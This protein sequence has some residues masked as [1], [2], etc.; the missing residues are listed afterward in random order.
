MP[1]TVNNKRE[2]NALIA[3]GIDGSEVSVNVEETNLAI[4]SIEIVVPNKS[5]VKS[6]K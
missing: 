5:K 2:F 4:E 1:K 3:E 6:N